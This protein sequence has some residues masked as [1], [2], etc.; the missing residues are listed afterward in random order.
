MGNGRKGMEIEIIAR[1]GLVLV[2]GSF[3]AALFTIMTGTGEGLLAKSGFA[4]DCRIKPTDSG[5]K[6]TGKFS[7]CGYVSDKDV[8]RDAGCT[9]KSDKKE[10]V[11]SS[12]DSPSCSKLNLRNCPKA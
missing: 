11:K 3:L 12:G 10:C 4:N 7:S 2:I 9:W 1:V 5:K 6:C 8:C